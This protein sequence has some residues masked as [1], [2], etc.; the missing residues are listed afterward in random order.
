MQLVSAQE[1]DNPQGWTTDGIGKRHPIQT[2]V[3]TLDASSDTTMAF[4]FS[5]TEG[6]DFQI[7]ED[8]FSITTPSGK[9]IVTF[10]DNTGKSSIQVI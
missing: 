9:N 8:D 7:T 2:L 1:G 3:A 5:L 4:F 10:N 6:N